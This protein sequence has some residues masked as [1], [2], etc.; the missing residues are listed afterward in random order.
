MAGEEFP[1]ADHDITDPGALVGGTRQRDDQPAALWSDDHA[2]EAMWHD[3]NAFP[4]REIAGTEAWPRGEMACGGRRR[5]GGEDDQSMAGA[6]GDREDLA[7]EVALVASCLE[8]QLHDVVLDLD[9]ATPVLQADAALPASSLAPLVR[10][11][12]GLD[13]LLPEL[14][15]L[16]KMARRAQGGNSNKGRSGADPASS[17]AT[18][19][20]KA[21]GRQA[22]G[23]E[24]DPAEDNKSMA[25][26]TE[27]ASS[28]HMGEAENIRK[29]G[30]KRRMDAG[31]SPGH[32]MTAAV[33]RLL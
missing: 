22:G 10:S 13:A 3:E 31:P 6:R 16:T 5:E 32:G 1:R 25:T 28:S 33:E 20:G 21:L 12:Q 18:A 14:R 15:G 11:L 30:K 4:R 2:R 27:I 29:E 9:A 17:D 26:S 7:A 8:R 19:S 23:Q 24:E